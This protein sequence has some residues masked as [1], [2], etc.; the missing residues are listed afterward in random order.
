[1]IEALDLLKRHRGSHQQYFTAADQMP[2]DGVIRTKWRD[3]VVE[4]D[5]DGQERVN[6]I[7]YEICVLQALRDRL[8]SKEIWVV[9]ADRYR[10]PDDD[11]PSDFE[12]RRGDYYEALGL[13]Q[14][15]GTF[16]S[17][18][19]KAMVEGLGTLNRGMP[20]NPSVRL[21]TKGEKRIVVTPL[22]AQPGPPNLH[23]LKAEVFTRWS[24]TSLLMCSR[25]RIC[26]SASARLFTAS[27]GV[28][29]STARPCSAGC[30]YACMVWAP[31]PV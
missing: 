27:P 30:C 6:R 29:F 5:K 13:P 2:L 20:K 25:K 1:M 9:G 17:A 14:D 31:I 24:S 26:A 28:R 18:L 10:N 12:T 21:R 19:Q 4:R 15:P 3:I 7:N 11:L 8:R 22:D 23:H 16:I